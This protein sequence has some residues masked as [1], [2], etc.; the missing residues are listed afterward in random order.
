MSEVTTCENKTSEA[1][2]D[3]QPGDKSTPVKPLD[4]YPKDE[5]PVKPSDSYPKDEPIV[6]P[7]DSYPKGEPVGDNQ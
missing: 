4:S 3:N 7:L 5:P 2:G 1:T 6:K